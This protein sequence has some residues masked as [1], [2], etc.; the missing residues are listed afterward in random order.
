MEQLQW[1]SACNLYQEQIAKSPYAPF[2][3]GDVNIWPQYH[4]TVSYRAGSCRHLI[5]YYVGQLLYH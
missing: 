3:K 2:V 4:M 5:S 1:T